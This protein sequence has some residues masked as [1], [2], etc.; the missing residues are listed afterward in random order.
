MSA[1]TDH[2]WWGSEPIMCCGGNIVPHHEMLQ[3]GC[4]DLT[5][6]CCRGDV[7][8]WVREAAM[9]VLPDSIALMYTLQPTQDG[10]H[11]TRMVQALL[12]QAVERIA[13]L[14]EVYALHHMHVVHT[15]NSGT[16]HKL[17]GYLT[18]LILRL[19]RACMSCTYSIAK[20]TEQTCLCLQHY[21]RACMPVHK[22]L[23][24]PLRLSMSI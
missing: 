15:C 5:T 17:S 20:A 19:D 7:G 13:R 14:R 18:A 23:L 2:G 9:E 8:S 12:K 10:Q 21:Q 4:S 6:M 11:A 3:R 22:C 24:V 16:S 1:T